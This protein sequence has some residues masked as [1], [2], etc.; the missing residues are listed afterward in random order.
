MT[1]P[2]ICV[3][4]SATQWQFGEIT[5]ESQQMSDDRQ[6]YALGDANWKCVIRPLPLCLF[7]YIFIFGSAFMQKLA[8]GIYWWKSLLWPI[9]FKH[10]QCWYIF[11]CRATFLI[12]SGIISGW[13][14]RTGSVSQYLGMK[15]TKVK[16]LYKFWLD[17]E[18][19][20]VLFF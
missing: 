18:S 4:V 7:L 14:P 1:L 3:C 8:T 16:I 13:E 11:F 17:S 9:S 6:K 5:F 15:Q 12:P 19:E 10:P 20:V 2:L